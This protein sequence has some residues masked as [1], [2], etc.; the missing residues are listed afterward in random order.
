MFKNIA[1]KIIIF[2]VIFSLSIIVI[3]FNNIFSEDNFLVGYVGPYSNNQSFNYSYDSQGN[4]KHYDFT[5][6]SDI[7]FVGY[8]RENTQYNTLGLF[9]RF[10]SKNSFTLTN[11]GNTV[12]VGNNSFNNVTYYSYNQ[13]T[14]LTSYQ[15]TY[16][17][18]YNLPTLEVTNNSDQNM[19]IGDY[20]YYLYDDFS[21]VQFT[22]YESNQ[23]FLSW[24]QGSNPWT[25]K[26]SSDVY[27]IGL[28]NGS[29]YSIYFLTEDPNA[30]LNMTRGNSNN[31]YSFSTVT[32]QENKTFYYYVYSSWSYNP[33]NYTYG[34]W[35][36]YQNNGC[37]GV[38]YQIYYNDIHSVSPSPSVDYGDLIV[39]YS[40]NFVS[41]GSSND[42]FNKDIITWD[43]Y[44]SK[45]NLIND[46]YYTIE[47]RAI[48]GY[49]TGESKT[50][51][52]NQTIYNWVQG[53][54]VK[55][56]NGSIDLEPFEYYT[57]GRWS[58]NKKQ[59]EFTWGEV[60]DHFDMIDGH[61]GFVLDETWY[62]AGWRYE[63]R[64]LVGDIEDPDYVSE[65]QVIYQ[66]TAVSPSTSDDILNSYGNGLSPELY[67]L[68]QTVNTLN[69]TVQNWNINGVPIQM[70]SNQT[71]TQDNSWIEK[72]VE[73]IT[74]LLG[75]LIEGISNIIQAIIGLGGDIIE[76]LFSIVSDSISTI[77]NFFINL[78][79]DFTNLFNGFNFNDD[80]SDYD[81]DITDINSD[82]PEG[83]TLYDI[84]PGFVR[85]INNSGLGF[86]IWMP[87]I[88][89]IIYIV[90]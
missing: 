54:V 89:G 23:T 58:P 10:I 75:S 68:L 90:L 78:W 56:T 70:T 46:L 29:S 30:I 79:D 25:I 65:W 13:S 80:N 41:N 35:N 66:V 9:G 47:L 34:S 72:L 69:N 60:V 38:I 71:I 81:I 42:R 8:Y 1:R 2:V 22:H 37:D 55:L 24:T 5:S 63:I 44:D 45:G 84:I 11:N 87:L 83:E 16:Y 43:N 53:Y 3:P 62:K 82:L 28:Y 51:L 88:V 86:F 21:N 33:N 14:G 67:Q 4:F 40:T 6:G 85:M 15:G 49:Y 57:L 77:I 27:V 36:S 26:C 73:S 17:K 12:S 20:I 18:P 31:N 7:Y 74:N 59:V 61:V 52:L 50:Q 48:P 32:K 19:S 39:G 76:G 64:Y